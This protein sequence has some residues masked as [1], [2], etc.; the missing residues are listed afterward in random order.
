MANENEGCGKVGGALLTATFFAGLS[1]IAT[2]VALQAVINGSVIGN[3]EKAIMWLV[4]GVVFVL[5]LIWRMAP[6]PAPPPPPPQPAPEPVQYSYICDDCKKGVDSE[7]RICPFCQ[8]RFSGGHRRNEER[9]RN[10]KLTK[11]RG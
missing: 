1:F 4:A 6:E 8:A 3:R 10:E 9:Q 11:P 2:L 7:A 5:T